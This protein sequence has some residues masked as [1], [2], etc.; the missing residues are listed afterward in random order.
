MSYKNI[1]DFNIK[2]QKDVVIDKPV[3]SE[4]DKVY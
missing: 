2:I 3:G 4:I 1:V